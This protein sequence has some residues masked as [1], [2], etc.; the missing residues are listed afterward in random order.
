VSFV[1]PVTFA[2]SPVQTVA[3]S[4]IAKAVEAVLEQQ[5]PNRQIYDLVEDEVHTL[6]D[7]LR[8]MRGWLGLPRGRELR[9]PESAIRLA[10]RVADSLAWLGWRSPLRTT[11]IEEISAGVE[12]DPAP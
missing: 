8:A 7:I 11:A 12:G 9:V 4:D 3:A 6:S 2:T 10:A 1:L 5:V